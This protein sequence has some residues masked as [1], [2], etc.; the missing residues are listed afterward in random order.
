MKIIF[1]I[2]FLVLISNSLMGQEIVKIFGKNISVLH[3][4]QKFTN[5]QEYKFFLDGQSLRAIPFSTKRNRTMF[6]VVEGFDSVRVGAVLRSSENL[7][8]SVDLVQ[9]EYSGEASRITRLRKKRKVRKKRKRKRSKTKRKRKL[10]AKKYAGRLYILLSPAYN[11]HGS[12]S[13]DPEE[14][15]TFLDENICNSTSSVANC[16]VVDPGASTVFNEDFSV[17]SSAFGAMLSIGY[18]L[19]DWLSFDAGYNLLGKEELD[20]KFVMNTTLPNAE[21]LY[22]S[23]VVFSTIEVNFNYHYWI[24]HQLNIMPFIGGNRWQASK[25]ETSK[26]SIAPGQQQDFQTSSSANGFG[27][28]LGLGVNYHINNKIFTGFKGTYYPTIGN[29]QF[30]KQ[31]HISAALRFGFVI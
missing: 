17:K 30:G 9:D 10:K 24:N 8:P 22:K 7:E 12:M 14:V 6:K 11:L 1:Q 29:D 16:A 4:G 5:G 21:E 23:E 27:A 31:T 26:L 3:K 2:L 25:D 18:F 20:F 19:K 28:H 15:R 13:N